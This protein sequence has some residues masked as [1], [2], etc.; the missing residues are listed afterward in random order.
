MLSYSFLVKIHI[1]VDC[2]DKGIYPLLISRFLA[3]LCMAPRANLTASQTCNL[4]RLQ[5]IGYQG[6]RQ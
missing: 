3:G 4:I 2:Y 5:F 6:F 1:I